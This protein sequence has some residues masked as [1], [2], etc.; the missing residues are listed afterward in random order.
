MG[1]CN[2]VVGEVSNFSIKKNHARIPNAN[3]M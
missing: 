2:M 3:D 1:H